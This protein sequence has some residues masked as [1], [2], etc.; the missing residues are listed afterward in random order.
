[1]LYA[2][3]EKIIAH[4]IPLWNAT[5]TPLKSFTYR[6]R[7]IS[8]TSVLYDPDPQFSDEDDDGPKQGE[9]EDEDDF[10]ERRDAWIEA[11]RRVVQPEPEEDFEPP[12]KIED[13]VDLRR[14]YGKRGLQI[15]V[16]L[17][18]IHLTPEK[19]SYEG[20][21]WHVEGQLVKFYIYIFPNTHDRTVLLVERAYMRFRNIL[22]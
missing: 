3:I 10:G 1:M 16:K 20:G 14:D 4:T 9:G 7:R 15:I 19:P 5:L 8:Y 11:T 6:P 21:T 18:N 13:D 2:T 12:P 22:L 17:A